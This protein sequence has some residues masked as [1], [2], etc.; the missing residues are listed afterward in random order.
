MV[1]ARI[2]ANC[3]DYQK[4]MDELE[5]VLSLNTYITAN[6]LKYE[7]WLDPLRDNPRFKQLM[8]DYAFSQDL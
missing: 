8:A 2:Y 3:G 6:T 7:P 4:A 1:M 5:L